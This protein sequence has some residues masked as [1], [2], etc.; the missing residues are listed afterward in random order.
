MKFLL[1]INGGEIT[2]NCSR[3]EKKMAKKISHR[4]FRRLSKEAIKKCHEL[5]PKWGKFHG[6]VN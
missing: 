1:K 2:R 4:S 5:A 6:W 3:K